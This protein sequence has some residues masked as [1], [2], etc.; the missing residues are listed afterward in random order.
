MNISK[1]KM[2]FSWEQAIRLY[3]NPWL[4]VVISCNSL[5]S[6]FA[7]LMMD[8]FTARHANLQSNITL[9]SFWRE[10]DNSLMNSNKF[11]LKALK[12]NQQDSSFFLNIKQSLQSNNNNKSI[13]K[14][15]QPTSF[16]CSN[17][18]YFTPAEHLLRSDFSHFILEG[19]MEI[20]LF[21]VFLPVLNCQSTCSPCKKV[22]GTGLQTFWILFYLNLIF[23]RCKTF[24]YCRDVIWDLCSVEQF[25]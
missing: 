11:L 14:L 23:P 15:I 16:I 7:C 12:T 2:V 1:N 3:E 9:F 8:Q 20:L 24:V 5:E 10:Q 4:G 17:S 18:F 25:G 21:L 6:Q 22:S 13:G 19:G